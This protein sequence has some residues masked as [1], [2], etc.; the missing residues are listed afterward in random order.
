MSIPTAE[1]VGDRRWGFE[2]QLDGN[3][4]GSDVLLLNTEF[5]LGDHFEAGVDLE[6][7]REGGTRLLLNGKWVFSFGE[8]R[9]LAVGF[10]NI[11]H[12]R[13]ATP[14][15]VGLQEFGLFRG[16][17]GVLQ[18]DAPRFFLGADRALTERVTLMADHTQGPENFSSVGAN[19]QFSE[20][21][22]LLTGLQ[23]SNR[24]DEARFTVHLVLNAPI[25]DGKGE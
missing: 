13:T 21:A 2:A 19:V 6:D 11:G 12:H 5:G 1:T 8:E 22:G 24:G 14:Y 20:W 10:S 9:A 3:R 16:H 25:H 23:F 18:G 7:S 17:L 4:N 15:V